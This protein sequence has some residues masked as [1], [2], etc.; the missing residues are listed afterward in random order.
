MSEEQKKKTYSEKLRDFF[1]GDMTAKAANNIK[2]QKNRID[3]E[4]ERQLNG[5]PDPK[6][7]QHVPWDD[8]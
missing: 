3:Q 8:K 7:G 6:K 2:N 5:D 4:L 1:M